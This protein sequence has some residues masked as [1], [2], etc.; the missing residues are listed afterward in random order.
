MTTALQIRLDESHNPLQMR[1]AKFYNLNMPRID[2]GM[3]S[4]VKPAHKFAKFLIQTSNKVHKCKTYDKAIDDLIYRIRWCK[5]IN[6]KFWNLDPHQVWCYKKLSFR[7]KAIGYKQVLRVKYKSNKI[8][9]R[10]KVRLVAQGFSQ[11]FRVDFTKTFA[12]TIRQEFPRIYFVLAT[13]LA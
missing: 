13:L 8:I 6:K 4:N 11:V 12:P 10:Y 2:L 9:E 3:G 5:A 7:K 1:L